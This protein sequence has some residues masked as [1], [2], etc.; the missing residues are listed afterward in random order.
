MALAR[1]IDGPRQAILTAEHHLASAFRSAPPIEGSARDLQNI[2]LALQILNDL[3][4][5]MAR[6]ASSL[7]N[8]VRVDVG[9]ALRGLRLERVSARLASALG[10]GVPALLT[11]PPVE[12]F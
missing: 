8:D 7:P 2:D 4:G 11:H 6:L 12:I 1:E 5:F 10:A 9:P 3:E